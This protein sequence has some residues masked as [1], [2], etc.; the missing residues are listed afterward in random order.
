MSGS[1]E[2]AGFTGTGTG[3]VTPN[4]E[5]PDI[6]EPFAQWG[7]SGRCAVRTPRAVQ[8]RAANRAFLKPEREK[9]PSDDSRRPRLVHL[10]SRRDGQ[11]PRDAHADDLEEHGARALFDLHKTLTTFASYNDGPG[12]ARLGQDAVGI[13]QSG[14]CCT[15]FNSNRGSGSRPAI[16]PSPSI[17]G[18]SPRAAMQ[19]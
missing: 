14:L 7:A 4:R 9:S 2:T 12:T 3:H 18:T 11:A 15:T 5:T 13:K 19:R 16:T 1:G 17:P 6:S 10:R 8:R